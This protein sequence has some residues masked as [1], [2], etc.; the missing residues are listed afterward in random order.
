[1][2]CTQHL[3]ILLLSSLISSLPAGALTIDVQFATGTLFT[4]ASEGTAKAAISAA[5]ADLSAA[6]TS[7]LSSVPTDEF[8]GTNASTSVTF[9][10]NWDST[11]P[12][13][14][15]QTPHADATL[16]ADSVKMF[17][18]TSNLT[19]ISLGQGGPNLGLGIS[20]FGFPAEFQPA[21]DDAAAQ[22][23]AAYDRGSGPT[24]G[25]FAGSLN[26]PDFFGSYSL[27]YGVNYGSLWFDVDE[28][29]N[30]A[31]D[32][33]SS[34]EDY[35]HF[36]HTISVAAGK[37]DLYSVALHEMM[38]ALG[39]GTST[40]WNSQVSGTT[41]LGSEVQAITGSGANLVEPASGHI[42]S[43]TQSFRISDGAAQEVVMDPSNL[44]GSRKE[45][46]LLDLAFL[47]DIGYETIVPTFPPDYDG[48]GD[49][50]GADLALWEASYGVDTDGTDFLIW[51]QEYTGPLPVSAATV[52]PEPTALTLFGCAT[53]IYC[54]GCRG[55]GRHGSLWSITHFQRAT[56]SSEL[57]PTPPAA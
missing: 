2:R 46:T 36:D 52:V 22:S 12:V 50:D 8:I 9:D 41:W 17:V 16:L 11:D 42:A 48:D 20:I 21:L 35:W 51:Q 23:E 29:N 15:A 24:I 56:V 53:I 43:G 54:W 49:V 38:H 45:L 30:G 18:G 7:T 13:T 14:G 40:S 10:W 26:G 3:G 44:V 55:Q 27:D 39:S 32:S 31:K 19:G 25:T 6:I 1:M 47:R 34:L 37:N 33:D 57:D 5:A 4:P 28:N